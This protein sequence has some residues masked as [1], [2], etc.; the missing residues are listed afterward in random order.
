MNIFINYIKLIIFFHVWPLTLDH[1]SSIWSLELLFMNHQWALKF[2][3]SDA[4]NVFG[5]FYGDHHI[6]EFLTQSLENLFNH[7]S[8]SYRFSI[9]SHLICDGQHTSE[10]LLHSFRLKVIYLYSYF[11]HWIHKVDVPD[12]WLNTLILCLYDEYSLYSVYNSSC[13]LFS[14]FLGCCGS[15]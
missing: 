12:I 1:H 7:L 15:T 11:I 13:K 3:Q 2:S 10:V 9:A 8:I 14:C 5:L 6:H 4:F